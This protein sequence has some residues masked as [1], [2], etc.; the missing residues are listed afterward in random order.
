MF[1]LF[2]KHFKAV[3]QYNIICKVLIKKNTGTY[4]R[5]QFQM[6]NSKIHSSYHSQIKASQKTI[7]YTKI[8]KNFQGT[9]SEA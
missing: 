6:S 5:T 2:K 9:L 3:K 7:N 4:K 1:T 8:Y